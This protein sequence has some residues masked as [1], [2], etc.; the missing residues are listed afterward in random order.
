[1]SEITLEDLLSLVAL[2]LGA[3]RVR[4]EHRLL[5]DL[6]AESADLLNLMVA[7]EDRFKVRIDEIEIPE[8]STVAD[9]YQL[10][11]ERARE[12]GSP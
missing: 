9:L 11:R 5:E 8:L 1:M 4:P 7:V 3:Q 6:R 2:Q 10:I 12:P